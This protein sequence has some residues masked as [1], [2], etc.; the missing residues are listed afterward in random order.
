MAA[1]E[2]NLSDN[3]SI[4]FSDMINTA[5]EIVSGGHLVGD[6]KY[7]I[8][9]EFQDI[10]VARYKLVKAI[11]DQTGAKLLC[12]GD[13]WQSIYRFTG[14]DISLFTNFESY[15]GYTK[16]MR[17]EKTY[18]NGAGEKA[19]NLHFYT[20]NSITKKP[21]QDWEE[22]QANTLGS[23]ILLPVDLI[24]Q[25]MFLFGLGEKI[26]CLNKIYRKE[27]YDRFA[28]LADFLGSSKQA[29]AIRMKRL[30]LLEREYLDNPFSMIEVIKEV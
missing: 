26:D 9:D 13:D 15:F 4:D 30:G 12:V 16:V 3:K 10:S 7:V 11:L 6:Y 1:Y 8:I 23:A 17:L 21:I 18:R 5:T 2:K 14:S 28:A 20:A 27:V 25:G 24:K 29:L 22:W 19:T